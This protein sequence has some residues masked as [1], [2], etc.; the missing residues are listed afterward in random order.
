MKRSDPWR[1]FLWIRAPPGSFATIQDAINAAAA[2][3]TI[4]VAVGSFD[5]DLIINKD[6]TILGAHFGEAGTDALRDAA[7]GAG[8]TTIIGTHSIAATGGVTIDGVR[9]LNDATTTGGGLASPTLLIQSGFDHVIVNSIF[10]SA[11]AGGASVDDTAIFLP[12]LTSG[13]VTISN[14]YFT[15]ASAGAFSTAS[16]GRGIW[17][18]GGGDDLTVTG[19][20]F[21]FV[22]TGINLDM[23]GD[24]A[25]T[26]NGN[27]FTTNGTA[28][29]VAIDTDGVQI[30][31]NT[32]ENVSED[33]N[34]RNVPTDVIFDAAVAIGTLTPADPISD[35]VVVFGGVGFDQL[36]GTEGADILD[37]NNLSAGNADD[38]LLSGRGGNDLLLGRGGNDTLEG[39]A[40]DDT[41][42]GG[43]DIDTARYSGMRAQF[44]VDQLGNG[45]LQV[46]DLRPGAPDGIDRVRNVENFV[47]LDGIF[48][49][50]DV[51]NK[52][53]VI[54]S[55]GGGETATVAVPE[56]LTAVTTV[57]A[58]DPDAGTALVYSISGGAD[59]ALFQINE[60]T[61]A[62]SFI[63]APNFEA[64]DDFDTNNSYIVQV[65]ASDG[66]LSD[67]QAITVNVS[68]A[69][70]PPKGQDFNA[71][72][73]GDIFWITTAVRS[74]CG[75]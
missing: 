29:T 12:P 38:D 19:N 13:A 6:V 68:N 16:W 15:G 59:A 46:V 75:R 34:F 39:G 7:G 33:F 44:R 56:D 24:S 55:N 71:D 72:G 17:F 1:P 49:A 51:V 73:M 4:S 18:D 23:S 70:E 61:G 42:D 27:T 8:E 43:A 63:N 20:T 64:P 21:E 60:L 41:L 36:F 22:R 57:S 54:T 47:F 5:E 74:R 40:G 45:D 3:D 67:D 62:L 11:V 65:R 25:A 37:G 48:A 10:F 66:A 14:N 50:S 28:V 52:A 31:D 9:F 35:P 58:T 26:V 30:A 69:A 32:F 53:P 2:G